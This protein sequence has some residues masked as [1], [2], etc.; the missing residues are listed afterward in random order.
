M[1]GYGLPRNKDIEC[2]DKVDITWYGLAP[3]RYGEKRR[4]SVK[5]RIRTVIKKVERSRKK[6]ETYKELQ[7]LK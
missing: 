4:S 6:V 2:P 1:R 5:R 3:S 7:E